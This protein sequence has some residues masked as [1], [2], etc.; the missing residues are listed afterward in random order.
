M[1]TK[2]QIIERINHIEYLQKTMP[3]V[4]AGNILQIEKWSLACEKRSLKMK[5]SR[6]N[7][8]YSSSYDK[9]KLIDSVNGECK[10]CGK[11]NKP[12]IDHIIPI[13]KG[14]HDGLSNL[15]VL[16]VSCNSKK[17]NR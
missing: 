7:G 16:C 1:L 14:G 10:I 6:V 8:F 13:S 11:N 2:E 12:S 15:Q 17:G 5:L 3:K 9:Q 4:R